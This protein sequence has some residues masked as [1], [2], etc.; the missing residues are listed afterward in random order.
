MNFSDIVA[1]RVGVIDWRIIYIRIPI[2]TLRVRRVGNDGI[3][4]LEAVKISG[5]L[6]VCLSFKVSRYQ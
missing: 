6:C 4:L 2:P 5:D 1:S 3:R